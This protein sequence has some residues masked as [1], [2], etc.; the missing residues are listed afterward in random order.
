MRFF[1]SYAAPLMSR[2]RH[3]LIGHVTFINTDGCCATDGQRR[4]LCVELKTADSTEVVINTAILYAEVAKTLCFRC[5]LPLFIV[6]TGCNFRVQ[7]LQ[8]EEEV[9]RQ[10]PMTRL[11]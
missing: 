1:G 6:V 9:V 5:I 8:V 4:T 2:L 10:R 3:C 7:E 11:S